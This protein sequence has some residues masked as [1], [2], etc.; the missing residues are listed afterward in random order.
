MRM[1]CDT[2]A[3]LDPACRV[4]PKLD[5]LEDILDD[6]FAEPGR[7]VIVFSEWERMLELVRELLGEM[8]FD[9]AWHTGSVPQDRRRAEINRF[10]QDP[11]AGCSCPPTAAASDSTCRSPAPW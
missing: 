6:L 1:V 9:F 8:G 2:P 4:S 5:E 7:K 10:K 3:I 11:P